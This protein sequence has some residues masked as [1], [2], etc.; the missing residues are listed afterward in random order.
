MLDAS[1]SI[2]SGDW[3]DRVCIDTTAPCWMETLPLRIGENKLEL[4]FSFAKNVT[5]GKRQTGFVPTKTVICLE[6]LVENVTN[7]Q[8]FMIEAL[9]KLVA[10]LAQLEIIFRLRDNLHLGLAQLQA[11]K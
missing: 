5:K 10:V 4:H 9:G 7:L 8:T 11:S 3:V 6:I 2:N 1:L